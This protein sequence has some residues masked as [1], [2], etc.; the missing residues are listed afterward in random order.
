MKHIQVDSYGRCNHN[1]GSRNGDK[2]ELLK[3]YKFY[4]AF[5]NSNEEDYVTEKVYQGLRVGCVPSMWQSQNI[6]LTSIAC[7]LLCVR[8]CVRVSARQ[9]TGLVWCSRQF[10]WEPRISMS[11]YHRQRASSLQATIR[12][13]A[14]T[15]VQACSCCV[16]AP[17]SLINHQYH[18]IVVAPRPKELADYIKMVSADDRLYNMHLEWKQEPFTETFLA[19]LQRGAVDARCRICTA[20]H[21]RMRA[22]ARG[23]QYIRKR[24]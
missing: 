18:G 17:Q 24:N 9:V 3:G 21:D 22:E 19:K 6:V 14:C 23:E 20:I 12:M 7:A 11:L 13:C 5:E 10:T 2:M 1:T 4:L 15:I 8:V 16:C